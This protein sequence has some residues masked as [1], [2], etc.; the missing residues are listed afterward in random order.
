MT[1]NTNI[2]VVV[3]TRNEE[4]YL[5]KCL[6]SVKDIANEIIV[7]DMYSTDNS[8]K[9]AKEF[10]AKVYFHKHM[11]VVEQARNFA[12]KKAKG[13]WIL[14]LDPDEYLTR[15]LKKELLKISK[16]SNVDYV[17][18]PRKNIIFGKWFRHSRWW[19]DYLIRF[20]KKE[21]I[22]W[23]TE[24]HS[25]PITKGSGI[26]LLDNERF[27][28]RHLHYDSV[29]QYLTR[30]LRYSARQADELQ[31]QGYRIKIS[32][33]VVKPIGEFCSRFFAGTG[34]KDG[35]HGLV[36]SIMQA[37]SV[38]LI[39]IQ[40]WSLQGFKPRPIN[41]DT[42]LKSSRQAI[43]EYLHWQ[44]HYLKKESS[45]KVELL[46]SKIKHGLVKFIKP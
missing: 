45:N 28:I 27:A 12:L 4:K 15:P 26:T 20:F 6:S 8:A 36:L 22:K 14:L 21:S 29:Q 16:R 30:A 23:Q 18:I 33:L 43:F 44:N 11:P 38:A 9:V 42:F 13:P 19:P 24:I 2:S 35:I 41:K 25:Q 5:K 7:V 40:L 46:A 39:Y 17:R 32:D 31:K 3:N 10:G 37:F 1:K 34:Y